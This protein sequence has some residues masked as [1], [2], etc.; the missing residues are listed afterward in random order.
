MQFANYTDFRNAVLRMIDGDDS[1]GS[2]KTDT[3]DLLIGMGEE[4]VYH[5]DGDVP[6]LRTGDMEAALSLPVTAN[7]ATLPTDCLELVRV[8]FAGQVP[9]DYLPTQ[10]VADRLRHGGGTPRFYTEQGRTL[11]FYPAASGTVEGRYYQRPTDIKLG[12]SA[13]FVRYPALFLYAALAES[14]PFIGEDDRLPMWK[15]QWAGWMRTAQTAER[16]RATAGSR[17]R[18]RS[19]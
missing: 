17:L 7:A 13:V 11:T 3:L 10:E 12:L 18:M 2:I 16:N 4:R 19:R 1:L 5:G 14:A 15:S 8:Q 9:L 6:G